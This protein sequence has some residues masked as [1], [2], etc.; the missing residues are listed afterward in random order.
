M[1]FKRSSFVYVLVA[2]D[3]LQG[4]TSSIEGEMMERALKSHMSNFDDILHR[5]KKIKDFN[6]DGLVQLKEDTDESVA[7]KIL[8]RFFITLEESLDLVSVSL[9]NHLL[10][11]VSKGS[12]KIAGSADLVGF[13]TFAQKSRKI[14]RDLKSAPIETAEIHLEV[15]EYLN[16]GQQM[17][18]QMKEAFPDYKNQI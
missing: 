14:S 10:G 7:I 11:D 6:S 9:K 15:V 16:E 12:H 18:K 13:S 1:D 3:D 17:L 8:A 5:F 4:S 2:L